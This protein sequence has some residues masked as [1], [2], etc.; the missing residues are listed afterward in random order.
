MIFL[1]IVLL[2]NNITVSRGGGKGKGSELHRQ[3]NNGNTNY[4]I[5]PVTNTGNDY[6]GNGKVGPESGVGGLHI[7]KGNSQAPRDTQVFFCMTSKR[8][9]L[10]GVSSPEPAA[11]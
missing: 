11:A 5:P 3:N 9:A 2:A 7:P 6:V 1:L 4:I 8:P 10:R